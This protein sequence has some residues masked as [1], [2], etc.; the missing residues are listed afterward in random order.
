MSANTRHALSLN[1]KLDILRKYD[2][3]LK[4]GQRDAAVR[5][6][7]SQSVLGR[8]LKNREDIEC[9]AL[10]NE[11]QSRKRKRCGKD[12]TVERALK[13][14]FVKVRNKDARVS[15]PCF[16]KKLKNWQKKWGRLTSKQQKGGS[17]GG[18]KEKTF[19]SKKCTENKTGLYLRAIPEHTYVLQNDKAKGTK[20]CK[21]RITILCCATMTEEKKKLLVVGKSKQPHCFK[22]VKALAC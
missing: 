13:E 15:G 9:E 3:L 16:A 12:D 7:I 1:D 19:V 22:R 2:Q 8:I 21:E 20:Y 5:L 6:N 10:Q 14:W 11:S 17:I 4:M 18:K